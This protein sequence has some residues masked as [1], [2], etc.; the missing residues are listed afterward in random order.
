[1]MYVPSNASTGLVATTVEDCELRLGA[2]A[3]LEVLIF[4]V[5]RISSACS[6]VVEQRVNC[7]RLK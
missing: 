1:M 2:R 5:Q 6:T 4:S 3:C 7:G